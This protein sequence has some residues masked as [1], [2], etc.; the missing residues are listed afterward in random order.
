MFTQTLLQFLNQMFWHIKGQSLECC[1]PPATGLITVFPVCIPCIAVGLS[2][3]CRETSS[4]KL[5][6]LRGCTFVNQYV[7]IKYLGRGACGRVFL[8]MDMTDNR[9]YAV[10]VG[11]LCTLTASAR[12]VSQSVIVPLQ[13]I[14][15]LTAA[16]HPGFSLR[17]HSVWCALVAGK[18]YT[19]AFDTLSEHL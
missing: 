1:V 9:L 6:K 12:L 7:V 4:L 8:C 5:A 3:T 18:R 11:M 15:M 19:A 13:S 17:L 16:N 10:K 14:G 2:W